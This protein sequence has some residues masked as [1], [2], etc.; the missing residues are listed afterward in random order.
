MC[1]TLQSLLV[2]LPHTVFALMQ[3]L[4]EVCGPKRKLNSLK[5]EIFL[6]VHQNELYIF[7]IIYVFKQ[8]LQVQM[9]A[10]KPF[11]NLFAFN[12]HRFHA[13]SA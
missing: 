4:K 13:E 8:L 3:N 2:Q 9:N 7:L 5:T 10:K 12:F 1:K 11:R 6:I